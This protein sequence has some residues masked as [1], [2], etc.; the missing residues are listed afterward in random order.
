[1][2]KKSFTPGALH[3]QLL[4]DWQK[5]LTE[6]KSSVYSHG[7]AVRRQHP[8]IDAKQMAI[9]GYDL[10]FKLFP[11]FNELFITTGSLDTAC[12][13]AYLELLIKIDDTNVIYR[14]GKPCLDYAKEKAATLLAIACLKT[15]RQEAIET[16]LEFSK[17]GISPGGVADL[18]GVLLFVSQLFCEPLRC[19]Y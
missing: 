6:H 2:K 12:L 15:R 19:H 13:F 5:N 7:A 9:R 4:K 8:V 11:S 18:L 1:M 14:K 16:H 17:Q 10:I 3:L